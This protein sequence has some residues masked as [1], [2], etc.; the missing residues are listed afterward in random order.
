MPKA[1]NRLVTD[2]LSDLLFV[3]E[4][5]GI[6]NLA[7][8]SVEPNRTKFVGDVM[9]D[10]LYACLYRAV[11][12]QTTFLKIGAKS[13]FIK[14]VSESKF[15]FVTLH[16]PS[17]VDD[18]INLKS[19]LEALVKI[20]SKISLI[21]PIHP[22]T[23]AM[24]ANVQRGE[25]LQGGKIIRIVDRAM[26]TTLAALTLSSGALAAPVETVLY[27]LTSGSDGANA[28]AG[29][30]S[31]N[32][33]ALYDTTEIGG[34]GNVGTVLKLTPPANGQTAWTE[35][36]LYSFKGGSDGATPIAGLIAD[37]S[38]ALYGTTAGGG[39]GNNGTV[40][41]LTPPAKGQTAWTENVLHS[42]KGGSGGATPIAGLI[43]DN[44]GALYGTTAGGGSG[45]NGTVFKLTPPTKG[46]TA[47]TE[48]VLHSFKGGSGG[49]TPIAGLIADN[50]GALYGTTAGGGSGNNG[51]VF[52]LTPP[53]KGQT[54]WTETVL[55][56]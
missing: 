5:S 54:A 18:P 30:I 55:H 22:R 52:K 42:F 56:S 23:R 14:A 4:R 36:V 7:R 25:E 40:F 46:Q 1:V 29:L 39:S 12:A 51:T 27:S 15:G 20:S 10:T 26:I 28:L 41:K 50:S 37:N 24:I 38:G 43:A 6:D 17:N 49:A 47:W 16:R 32:Q 34:T 48:T 8:E 2:L 45:N 19:I 44:S 11:P 21:F 13:E 53:T 9:I 35:T 33:G 3:N 31:D